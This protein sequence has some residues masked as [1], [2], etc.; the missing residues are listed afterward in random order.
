MDTSYITTAWR[1]H[2]RYAHFLV[3]QMRPKTIVDLGIDEGYS[4]I[5]LARYSKGCTYGVDHFKGDPQTGVKNTRDK[6]L[7]NISKSLFFIEVMDMTF[8]KAALN[9][10]DHEIDI[11]HIDGAHDYASVKHDFETWFP[12][13]RSG[14]VILMHDTQSFSQDVGRFFHSLEYPHFEFTHSAGL[15]VVLKP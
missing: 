14:G 1:G 3:Q 10:H 8:D 4:T 15:G 11:L 5:E 9:F 2:E 6:A 13:V 7:D 12:K